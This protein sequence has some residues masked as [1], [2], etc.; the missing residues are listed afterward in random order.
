[1]MRQMF[2]SFFFALRARLEALKF[3]LYRI[4]TMNKLAISWQ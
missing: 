1:M 3:E 2:I 4:K